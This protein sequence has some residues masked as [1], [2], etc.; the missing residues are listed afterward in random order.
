MTTAERGAHTTPAPTPVSEAVTVER[1]DHVAIEV[2]DFDALVAR[3]E[4][5][6]GVTG[7]RIGRLGRD[8]SRRIAM[9]RD[10]TGFT[11]EII[12]APVFHRGAPTLD[13]IALRVREVDAAAETLLAAGFQQ[14]VVTRPVDAWRRENAVVTDPTGLVVQVV[15]YEDDPAD[16]SGGA[17]S[18]DC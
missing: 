1:I 15:R 3:M 4:V 13:H 5:A 9:L 7:T 12:E 10:A 11:L 2:R 16:P 18:P 8:P 17:G 6:L 14:R